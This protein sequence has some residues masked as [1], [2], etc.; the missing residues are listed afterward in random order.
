[1]NSM[2][3]LSFIAV[4]ALSVMAA[5]GG[6]YDDPV[7]YANDSA[8]SAC[9]RAYECMAEFPADIGIPF[10]AIFGNNEAMCL[11]Q[12]EPDEMLI[13]DAVAS[14]RAIY[15]SDA[16]EQCADFVDGL[17]CQQ[18]WD[19]AVTDQ[20][21]DDVWVGTQQDGASCNLGIECASGFCI[22]GTCDTF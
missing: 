19:P 13:E 6:K 7:V 22:Q 2:K 12:F 16:A 8:V 3:P 10:D 4:V 17:N 11:A 18:Y 14:G 15:D 1:M 21:C 9:S 20:S 5:C